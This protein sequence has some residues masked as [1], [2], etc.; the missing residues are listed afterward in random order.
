MLNI[1]GMVV[2]AFLMINKTNQVKFFKETFLVAN[3]SSEIVFKMSFLILN[4]ADIDIL[5]WELW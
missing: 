4:G 5:D 2:T 3:V 1:Y